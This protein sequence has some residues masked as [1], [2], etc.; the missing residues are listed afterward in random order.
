MPLRSGARPLGFSGHYVNTAE[1]SKVL[2]KREGHA[3]TQ[4]SNNRS[5]NAIGKTPAFVLVMAEIIPTEANVLLRYP[6]NAG[7]RLREKGVSCVNCSKGF[8][9]DSKQ[10]KQ[11]VN[12]VITRD[13]RP[14]V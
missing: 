7:N 10:S 5:A 14:G 3:N 11:L 4:P 9:T 2:I 1:L 8:T 12:Y 13:E 6:F